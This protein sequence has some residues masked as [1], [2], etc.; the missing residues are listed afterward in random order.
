GAFRFDGKKKIRIQTRAME[1]NGFVALVSGV[2][3]RGEGQKVVRLYPQA[4][5]KAMGSSLKYVTIAAGEADLAVRYSP[6]SLWDTAA[7]QCILEQAGGALLQF[8][9][10]PLSYQRGELDNPPFVAVGDRSF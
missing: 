10:S 8:D 9:G 6:T 1:P 2:H 5:V 7:A 3:G 4:T